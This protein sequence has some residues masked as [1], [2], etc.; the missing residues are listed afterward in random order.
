MK[1][2]VTGLRKENLRYAPHGQIGTL[3]DASDA[4]PGFTDTVRQIQEACK[5]VKL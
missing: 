5:G 4:K 2:L 1:C 3:D